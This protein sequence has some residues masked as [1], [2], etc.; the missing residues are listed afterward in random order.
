MSALSFSPQINA[1]PPSAASNSYGE[2]A[3]AFH[4]PSTILPLYSDATWKKSPAVSPPLSTLGLPAEVIRPLRLGLSLV[5][6]SS[7]CLPTSSSS[8]LTFL[9]ATSFPYTSPPLPIS[10]C[11]PPSPLPPFTSQSLCSRQ[12]SL[13]SSSSSSSSSSPFTSSTR[14]LPPPSLSPYVATVAAS[15]I[16]LFSSQS[17]R[18]RQ[19]SLPTILFVSSSFSSSPPPLL[20]PFVFFGHSHF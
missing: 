1:F 4:T 16:L 6:P 7:L 14:L 9:R 18:P 2:P 15:P 8:T 10:M 3:S 20:L 11:R 17:L 19:L 12:L 5:P 13:P